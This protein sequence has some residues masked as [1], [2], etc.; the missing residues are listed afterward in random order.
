[1]KQFVARGI[2]IEGAAGHGSAEIPERVAPECQI[3][4]VG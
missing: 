2:L 1:M 3:G 4:G